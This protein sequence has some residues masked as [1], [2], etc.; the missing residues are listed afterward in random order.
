MGWF[1]STNFDLCNIE[2]Q[3]M[4]FGELFFIGF[5]VYFFMYRVS[6]PAVDKSTLV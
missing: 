4:G 3:L 1:Q 5:L 2:G 6:T